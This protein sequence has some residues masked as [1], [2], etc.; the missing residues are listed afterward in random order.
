MKIQNVLRDLVFIAV[1]FA[2]LKVTP[3]YDHV[4]NG[5]SWGPIIEVAK[6]FLGIFITI[7]P[8]LAM[9]G[10]GREGAFSALVAA[11]TNAAYGANEKVNPFSYTNGTAL[12]SSMVGGQGFGANYWTVDSGT[13][14]VSTNYAAAVV[15]DVPK[16]LNMSNYPAM[17]GN[18]AYCTITSDGGVAKAQRSL[19]S[20]VTTGKFYVAFLMSYQF[21]GANKWAGLSL[22]NASGTEKAFLGKGA[23]ANY[24]TLGIGDGS[25]T[26]WSAYDMGQY[27][28]SD[29][30]GNTGNVYLVCGKYDFDTDVFQAKAYRILDGDAFPE[31]EPTSWDVSQTMAGIDAIARIQLNA[32][33]SVGAGWPGKVYFDEIR[34]GTDW[35]H[36]I[37][38]TCPTWAGSNTLNSAEWTAPAGSR[39][40][41]AVRSSTST[42][43]LPATPAAALA[44]SPAASARA[45]ARSTRRRGL[46]IAA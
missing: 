12:G 37:A 42:T 14:T 2:S 38:V 6:L 11:V 9:L 26:Y 8:V 29:G 17:A 40:A 39:A 4:A 34:Y 46:A 13:W 24:S 22:L 1:V 27:Y 44:R 10:A 41:I 28:S 20:S 31:T 19:A 30:Y 33:A 15:D 5:F 32:G 21:R 43:G 36:L 23:G 16:L 35:S 25:T 3:E 18:L 45:T 7:V